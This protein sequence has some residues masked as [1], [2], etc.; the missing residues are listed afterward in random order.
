MNQSPIDPAPLVPINVAIVGV[1][2]AGTSSLFD[3]LRKHPQVCPGPRKEW[4]FF[5]DEKRSWDQPDYTGYGAP[6]RL[7]RHRIAI[8]GTPAYLFWPHALERMRA[9]RPDMKLI[10][11]LRDPIERAFS[12]WAMYYG[13]LRSYPTFSQLAQGPSRKALLD[14]IP[15]DWNHPRMRRRSMI[16]RGLYGEQVQR[17]LELFPR[18][19]WLFLDF[20]ELVRDHRAALGRTTR[21]LGLADFPRT[22]RLPVIQ[23][24]RDDLLAPPPTAHDIT[25][26]AQLYAADLELLVR[27]SGLDVG[28][29]PTWQVAD[30]ELAASEFAERL[31]RKWGLLR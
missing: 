4:H 6:A 23:S 30:G 15:P 11:S 27:L 26:L 3:L 10:A 21:F 25:R 18:E 19:Q 8:D 17:G 5:D 20:H 24:T 31:A 2:K 1:Q 9:Y 7:Q 28:N 13:K 29:W 14:R 16:P 12:H 22:P